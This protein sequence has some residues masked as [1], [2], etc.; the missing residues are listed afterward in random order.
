MTTSK[1]VLTLTHA[2]NTPEGFK[3]SGALKGKQLR[4]Y[5]TSKTEATV[6]FCVA[7]AAHGEE[8]KPVMFGRSTESHSFTDP[9]QSVTIT[10]TRLPDPA[11]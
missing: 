2:A 7:L 11:A 9:A 10:L 8:P 4:W 6:A 1:F 5:F 3:V